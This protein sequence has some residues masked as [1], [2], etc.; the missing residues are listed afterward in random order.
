MY[1]LTGIGLLPSKFFALKRH[2]LRCVFSLKCQTLRRNSTTPHSRRAWRSSACRKSIRIRCAGRQSICAL[3]SRRRNTCRRTRRTHRNWSGNSGTVVDC[4]NGAVFKLLNSVAGVGLL[5]SR[6]LTLKRKSF[7]RHGKLPLSG[8][9]ANRRCFCYFRHACDGQAIARQ[10]RIV[11]NVDKSTARFLSR[12]V[13]LHHGN[14]VFGVQK[15]SNFLHP[16]LSVFLWRHVLKLIDLL[17]RRSHVNLAV[18]HRSGK[19]FNSQLRR[20]CRACV[21]PRLPK[22]FLL[23]PKFTGSSLSSS[24]CQ[25]RSCCL[26]F[27]FCFKKTRENGPLSFLRRFSRKTR[28]VNSS[29]FRVKVTRVQ[30]ILNGG[31][32]FGAFC[33]L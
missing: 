1:G 31:R 9:V 14:L 8:Y 3:C 18:S 20:V 6:F 33:G 13:R 23:K 28:R 26:T 22:F 30:F 16:P 32:S 7:L 25:C 2:T 15:L 4:D 27:S 24:L 19:L 17:R 29:R 11:L 5:P 12:N 21:F 10:I